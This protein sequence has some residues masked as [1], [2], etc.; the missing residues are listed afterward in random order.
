MMHDSAA[1]STL[2]AAAGKMQGS[3]YS[4][5]PGS[6]EFSKPARTEGRTLDRANSQADPGTFQAMATS[7][8]D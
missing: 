1:T 8:D 3:E 5:A 2:T 7:G 6:Q 4:F